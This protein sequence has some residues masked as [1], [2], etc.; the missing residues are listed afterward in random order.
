VL[1]SGPANVP[2]QRVILFQLLGAMTARPAAMAVRRRRLFSG[3]PR[4][5]G[6]EGDLGQKSVPEWRQP[7]SVV[8][9]EGRGLFKVHFLESTLPKK[10]RRKET[11]RKDMKPPATAPKHVRSLTVE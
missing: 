5:E 2:Q 7:G 10:Q 8:W 6:Q 11:E 3:R 9:V 1:M 4:Q